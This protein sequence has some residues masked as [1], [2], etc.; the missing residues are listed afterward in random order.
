[1]RADDVPAAD[2][3]R[4]ADARPERRLHRLEPLVGA[5]VKAGGHEDIHGEAD[6]GEWRE[7]GGKTGR[8]RRH[9]SNGA[10]DL[11]DANEQHDGAGQLGESR[12]PFDAAAAELRDGGGDE[13]HG[14]KD[15]HTPEHNIQ[16]V[17]CVH[18]Y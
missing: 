13:E 9:E 5:E 17:D 11:H 12:P 6:G 8:H 10:D 1:M 3:N 18:S 16:H 7:P 4:N 15:L 2:R 14:E